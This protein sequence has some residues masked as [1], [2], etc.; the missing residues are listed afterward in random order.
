MIGQKGRFSLL[1]QAL[2]IDLQRIAK[3]G[4]GEQQKHQH[5]GKRFAQ[6]SSLLS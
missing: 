6:H 3:G 5:K 4:A 1:V 2:E